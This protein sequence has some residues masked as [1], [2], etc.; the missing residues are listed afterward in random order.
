MPEYDIIAAGEYL[1]DMISEEFTENLAT[2]EKYRRL[3]GGSPANMSMNMA[4]LGNDVA[5]VACVG[6]DA[7][8]SFLI[9]YLSDYSVDHRGI[10]RSPEPTTI[11]L[12]TRS[13]EVSDFEVYRSADT[14]IKDN[15][16]QL[17][18]P[19]NARLFHTT[20]FGLS[21]E[22]ARSS[23]LAAAAK[24]HAALRQLSID[25]NYASKVW[26][27]LE[28]AQRVVKAYV[29]KNALVKI[30]LVDWERLYPK[31]VEPSVDQ[32]LDHFLELGAREVCLTLGGDGCWVATNQERHFI[33]SREVEVKDTTGAG[34]A[35]WSGYLTAWLE[36][37]TLVEKAK[38]GRKMAELKLGHFGPLP[39]TVNR[40][41]VLSG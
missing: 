7:T 20:C 17:I 12:V 25:L 21:K 18:N 9:D 39:K 10:F 32:V 23:I 36:N 35:F 37:K 38:A 4:R 3:P 14:Q 41:E 1:I 15:A 5:L 29:S 28:D 34:D 11:V 33:P 8:G 6:L 22:P 24:A 40:D 30:S 27:D 19:A 16:F 13:Q 31:Q 2:A 26:P